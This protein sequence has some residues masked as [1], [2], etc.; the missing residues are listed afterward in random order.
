MSVETYL[1]ENYPA[2]LDD[3]KSFCRIPSVSTDPAFAEGIRQAAAFVAARLRKA[4]F[5]A[6]EMLDTGGHTAVYGEI[7]SDPALPTYLVYGH[8]DVQPPD[9]LEKWKTPP[10]EPDERDGRLYARGVSDDKG[11]LLIPILV[12]EAFM[13]VEGR[14]PVNLKVLIEGEE[15]SGSPHFT[16]T[17]EKYRDKL[18][19]D[20]VLSADGAM[21]RPDKPSI[22]VA[23]RGLAALDIAITG[24]AKDLHSG[25]HGGSAPNPIAALAALLASMHGPDGCVSVDCFLD[26][27]TPP[28]PKIIAAIETSRFDSAAYYRE[29]GVAGGDPIDGG[30]ELLI[31]QWLEPTLE[32]NGI[33]GGYQGKGTKT[34]IPNVASAKITCRLIAGQKPDVVIAAIT[35]HLQDRLPKGFQLEVHRHGPGSEADFVDPDLPALKISEE[36]LGELLG[37]RPLRVAMG[38]T[39]PIGSAFRKHL[40]CASIFFSFSTAD[41]DYHAPNEFLR[42]GNFK[43]GMQAWT[44]LLRRLAASA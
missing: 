8:Y 30:R 35:R 34:V 19:C 3:L 28:D 27:A 10:F 16:Q 40:G 11:P 37:E 31:R 15:E 43:L 5:A 2:A 42:L 1:E 14:L 23:S 44:M 4:G 13:R 9:P 32:F 7:L 18:S 24:A 12:A 39:I 6:V 29:I 38:A 36:V 26:G 33:W 25:R 20:L 17:L 22:T 21:W 41:E